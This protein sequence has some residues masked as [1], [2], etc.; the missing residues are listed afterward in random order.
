MI[1]YKDI[2]CLMGKDG[3]GLYVNNTFMNIKGASAYSCAHNYL[4]IAYHD[5]RI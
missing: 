4:I 5:F 1:K 2:S 3:N